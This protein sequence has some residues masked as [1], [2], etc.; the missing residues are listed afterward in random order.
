MTVEQASAL[1][2]TNFSTF[3]HSQ[4]GS[5]LVRTMSYSV[6]S[7]LSSQIKFIYPTIQ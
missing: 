5:Q 1:F 7:S 2:G 6:P 3:T 4:S